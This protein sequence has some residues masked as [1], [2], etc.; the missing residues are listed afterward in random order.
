MPEIGRFMGVDL[1]SEKFTFQAPYNYAINNP[2]KYID[3][4]G[5]G[6]LTDFYNLNGKHVKH[7]E[8][9]KDDKKLVLTYSRSEDK[10]NTAIDEGSV[11]DVPTNDIVDKMEKVFDL[12]ETTGNEHEFMV[13]DNGR[14]SKII[15]GTEGKVSEKQML[16]SQKDLNAQG[17]AVAYDVHSH[18]LGKDA[19]G[20]VVDIGVPEPSDG[21]KT[22]Q[23]SGLFTKPSV[24]LGYKQITTPPPTGTLG[25]KPNVTYQR[26]IG[27]Y[28]SSGSIHKNTEI[29]FSKFKTVVRK[30]NKK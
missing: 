3:F 11:V 24:I 2:I 22:S 13:G 23:G 18:P 4:L 27:F 25:G 14:T 6:P 5:M 7:I 1:L 28:N 21:D 10:V 8:D 29:S 30:I 15:E 16:E 26:Q 20:V 9:G 12:S 19:N 17:D